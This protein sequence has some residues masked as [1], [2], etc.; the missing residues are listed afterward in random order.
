LDIGRL[1]DAYAWRARG[2]EIRGG[3][4]GGDDE[5]HGGEE[6]EGV[7][8]AHDGGVHGGGWLGTVRAL[9]FFDGDFRKL[10]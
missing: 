3:N 8:D 9:L 4:E 5:G 1:E 7:L 6:A 2:E 10:N